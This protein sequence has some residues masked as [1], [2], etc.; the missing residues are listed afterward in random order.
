MRSPCIALLLFVCALG[1]AS[2]SAQSAPNATFF[3]GVGSQALATGSAPGIAL[4]VV[5]RGRIVYEGGFGFAD[6]A[7]RTAVKADTPF[8]IGS[9]TK[10]LTAAAVALLAREGKLSLDDPVAKYVP[11]LPNAKQI[12]LRMLLDQNSGLHNYPKTT[13]HNWPLFGPISLSQ[14]V[15]ILATD[16]PDFAPGERWQYSNAN[17]TALAAV[18][19]EA[20]GIPLREFLTTRIF[21][22]LQM[23]ASGF[24]YA[25]QERGSIAVGYRNKD[26]EVPPLSL[27]LFSGAGAAVSSAHDLARWDTALLEGTLLPKDYLDRIWNAGVAT[28][29]GANRYAM[30]WVLTKLDG[31]R[32]MW[33]NGLAPEVGGY[34]Y[35]AI[36]PDDALAVVVLTNG[37]GAAGL[38]EHMTQTIAAAYG[39]G[40]APPAAAAGPS[41]A[42]ND[43]P[44]IDALV[45]AFW[46]QLSSGHVDR[47]KLTTEFS[48]ALTP[49]VLAQVR[50]GI[51]VLGDLRSFTFIGALES[52]RT[53]VYRYSLVFATGAEHEWNVAITSD[54]KIAGSR[55]V[56]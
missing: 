33:H 46:N 20:S 48:A 15:S 10:Q 54:G 7:A 38:P 31:H 27:D 25:A 19:E 23:S 12:T 9:L 16:K 24:G 55:L 35:N 50:Q 26:A 30:G 21:T 49:D 14:I 17:Y 42:P 18:V 2:V 37:F 41:Q 29:E 52:G 6:V 28:E 5:S 1:G 11:S 56:K 22:P 3:A 32:E 36:F 53:T 39:I 43:N 4:A 51:E 40:A 8:A 47:S 44:G 13:E 45:R 34:C